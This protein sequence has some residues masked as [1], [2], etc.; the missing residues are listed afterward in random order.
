MYFYYTGIQAVKVLQGKV[1]AE[2]DIL[3]ALDNL[4]SGGGGIAIRAV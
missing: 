2:H 4:F 3:V 1:S